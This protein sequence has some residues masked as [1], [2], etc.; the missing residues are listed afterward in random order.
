VYNDEHLTL[1]AIKAAQKVGYDVTT[2]ELPVTIGED[3]SGLLDKRPGVFAFIGSNSDYDL[4]HPKYDPDEHIL[5]KAPDYFITL[6]QQ[7][8]ANAEE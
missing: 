7:L 3:F 6:I 2:L 5:E 1:E 4:H 8:L